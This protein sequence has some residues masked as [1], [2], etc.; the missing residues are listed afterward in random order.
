MNDTV[1]ASVIKGA[2]ASVVGTCDAVTTAI[3]IFEKRQDEGV[4]TLNDLTILSLSLGYYGAP[5]RKI[6]VE[7]VS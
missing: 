5:Y 1:T 2:A 3:V 7:A 6:L 4:K